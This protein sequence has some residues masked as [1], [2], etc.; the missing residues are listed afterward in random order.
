MYIRLSEIEGVVRVVYVTF[1]NRRSHV[2]YVA[3]E[4]KEKVCPKLK[5]RNGV[6]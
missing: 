3:K 2:V 4:Y 1:Q 5:E 6:I